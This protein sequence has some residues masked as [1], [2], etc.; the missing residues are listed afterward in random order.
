MQTQKTIP[1]R[2]EVDLAG[3]RVFAQNWKQFGLTRM[4]PPVENAM[5]LTYLAEAQK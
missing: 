3:A 2:G 1:Q 4:P 5:D